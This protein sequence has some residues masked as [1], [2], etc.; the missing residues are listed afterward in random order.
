MKNKKIHLSR[1]IKLARNIGDPY[2]RDCLFKREGIY[3]AETTGSNVEYF[4]WALRDMPMI[5]PKHWEY[6]GGIPRLSCS[7]RLSPLTAAGVFF[8]LTM[9][10]TAHL[11]IPEYQD[12]LLGPTLSKT[13]KPDE[14]IANIYEFVL[15]MESSYPV[16]T[17]IFK[18]IEFTKS[19]KKQNQ[20]KNHRHA[21]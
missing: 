18:S 5:F 21:A 20:F 2:L 16:Q 6:V 9:D 3:V 14:L 7:P 19:N 17:N 11:L 15:C 10:S 4:Y 13:A 12:P 8:G 1:L